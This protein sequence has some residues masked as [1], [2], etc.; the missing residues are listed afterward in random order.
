M[1]AAGEGVRIRLEPEDE[2]THPIEEAENFNESMYFNVFDPERKIGGWFR[3]ANRPNEGRGEM[4]CCVYLPDGRIGFMFK[5]PECTAN[6]AFENGGMKFEVIEPFRKVRISYEG[7]LCVLENPIEMMDPGKAFKSNPVV[8]SRIEID[9]EGV[10]PMFGGEPVKEDGSKIEQ[11]AEE[12][13]ARGHYE[14]HIEGTGHITVGDERFEIHGFGLRDHSWGPR[15]WQNI[16]WYRWLPMNFGR[17]FAMMLSIVTRPNG[18]QRQGGMVLEN[19]EYK[20]IREVTIRSEYDADDCQTRMR[21]TAR[22]DER[23]YTVTGEVMSLIPLRNRRTSPDGE[24]LMTRITEGMT[25]YECDGQVGY[26]LS[27]YL[28][29]IVDGEPVGKATG[30]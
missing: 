2:Y 4:S 24:E 18:E 6:D 13:F 12:A 9:Y 11:K 23:E 29:Q 26:G 14:Q 19:G 10:S 5:R 3:L 8:K 15:Y 28:D 21:C 20:L 22:T 16:F 25:R 1:A 27:E 30:T 7:S 17:D